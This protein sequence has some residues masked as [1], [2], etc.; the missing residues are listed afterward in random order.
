MSSL[1][2]SMGGNLGWERN[3]WRFCVNI[4]KKDEEI[5]LP[6]TTP[7]DISA[8]NSASK[9]SCFFISSSMA[10]GLYG[11]SAF[12]SLIGGTYRSNLTLLKRAAWCSKMQLRTR[13]EILMVGERTIE[14]FWRV[15]LFI[16]SLAMT[17]PMWTKTH[18]INT[19]LHSGN[20]CSN[21]TRD[22]NEMLTKQLFVWS[23]VGK[24]H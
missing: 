6:T 2:L 19:L 10:R 8:C 13:W 1:A 14:T 12:G 22:L 7:L 23:E 5:H 9:L 21:L 17:W 15:I 16:F 11:S 24:G 18:C 3:W 20:S 4:N